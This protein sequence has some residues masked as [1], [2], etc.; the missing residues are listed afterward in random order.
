MT[1]PQKK[2]KES[3]YSAST[4]IDQNKIWKKGR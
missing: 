3:N 2:K 1:Q 4:D